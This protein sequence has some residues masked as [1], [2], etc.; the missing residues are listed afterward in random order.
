MRSTMK[1]MTNVLITILIIYIAVVALY[2]FM[3]GSMLFF[4]RPI[5]QQVQVDKQVEEVVITTES[6]TLLHGW[7]CK[8]PDERSQKLI[9]YFGGNAEEVSHMIDKAGDFGGWALLLINYPGYGKSEGRPGEKSFFDAATTIWDYAVS[10]A[11]IDKRNIVLM[12]R[13]IGT[14]TAVYLAHKKNPKAV[15]LVS[16]FESIRAVA[17]S[18]LPFLPIGLMLKHKFESGKYAAEIDVPLLAFYGTS[19]N[20]IPPKHTKK[21]TGQ[22]KGQVV[23][24]ELP[25]YGHNDIFESGQL[26]RDIN[27]F[28]KSL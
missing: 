2:Y 9:I 12:G 24:V 28:L 23:L 16:P 8:N 21:L 25:G 7:L 15:I 1:K 27:V 13:S 26:W 17:Q 20:I 11:D 10:R 6:G 14:G 3:Q 18:K 5:T 4:P 22:W 19:D